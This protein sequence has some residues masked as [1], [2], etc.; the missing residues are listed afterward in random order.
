M[1]YFDESEFVCNGESCFDKM[2]KGFLDKLDLARSYSD[3]PFV[4]TSSWRSKEH[5]NAVGGKPNSA[6]TRGLAVDLSAR[7]SSDR[8]NIIKSA[9]MA[10][11]ARIGISDTFIHLD[12]DETKPPKVLWLY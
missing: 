5:N 4:I 12:D 10:K 6:H 11:I 2:D 1:K 3:V 7:N 8:Y 9:I